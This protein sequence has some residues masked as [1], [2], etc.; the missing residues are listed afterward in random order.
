MPWPAWRLHVKMP[1]RTIDPGQKRFQCLEKQ[2]C[3]PYPTR[4]TGFVNQREPEAIAHLNP[5]H[6][7]PIFS[8]KETPP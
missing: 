3:I 5:A 6:V 4:Y 1:H 8:H 2:A 7:A